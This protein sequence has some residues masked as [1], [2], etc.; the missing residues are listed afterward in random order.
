VSKRSL[1]HITCHFSSCRYLL[2]THFI[3]RLKPGLC[4]AL[5]R[6][7]GNRKNSINWHAQNT[8][9]RYANVFKLEYID[10]CSWTCNVSSCLS[11]TTAKVQAVLVSVKEQLQKSKL[12]YDGRGSSVGIV[13]RLQAGWPKILV[14]MNGMRTG[15]RL[16]RASAKDQHRLRDPLGSF[17]HYSKSAEAWSWVFNST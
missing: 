17:L 7:K 12:L 8:T 4:R 3:T 10:Y 5:T 16:F 1:C 11:I 9:A 2:G 15:L 6:Q 13:T 14:S